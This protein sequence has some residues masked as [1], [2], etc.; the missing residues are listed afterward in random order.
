M[1]IYHYTSIETLALI[2]HSK[3]I[4]FNRLDRVD[5]VEESCYGSGPTNARLGMYS[6][7]SC[8]TKDVMENLS[9]WKMYTG[10]K[11]VRI[12]ID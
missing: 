3:K 1:K 6:F 9:L 2:L 11:G 12:G 5:D 10:Y 4:R 8:W 7:V